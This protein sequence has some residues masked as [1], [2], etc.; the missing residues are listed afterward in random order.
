MGWTDFEA[1]QSA[2]ESA[3]LDGVEVTVT[4]TI[5]CDEG[6]ACRVCLELAD[7][8]VTPSFLRSDDGRTFDGIIM[9]G[10]ALPCGN[11]MTGVGLDPFTGNSDVVWIGP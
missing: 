11:A 3:E 5:R 10:E 9:F 6:Y 4:E 2:V 1:Y 8:Q 7:P